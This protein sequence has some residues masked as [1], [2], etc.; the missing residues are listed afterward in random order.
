MFFFVVQDGCS[1]PPPLLPPRVGTTFV[2]G[3]WDPGVSYGTPPPPKWGWEEGRMTGGDW[4]NLGLRL[5]VQVGDKLKGGGS[6]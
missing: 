6:K 5:E 4:I 1:F 3:L 2:P